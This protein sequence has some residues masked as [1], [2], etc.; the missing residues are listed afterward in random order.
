M[1]K[2]KI[3]KMVFPQ[4]G[5]QLEQITQAL[6]EL[7][8]HASA[9]SFEFFAQQTIDNHG[10]IFDFLTDLFKHEYA[11]KEDARITRW[12]SQSKMKKLH[13]LQDFD[14]SRQPSI[15]PTLISEL[16]S[17]RFIDQGKNVIFL[18]PP[19]VG[20]THLA[21]ALGY[22]AIMKGYEMRF[23]RLNEFIDARRRAAASSVP[24]LHRSLL[25]PKL[26]ILDDVDYY[27]KDIEAG[28]FLFTVLKDRCENNLSTIIT[29]NQNPKD[30]DIF[31]KPTNTPAIL[32]RLFADKQSVT[33]NINGASTR[34][35][36][37]IPEIN[38]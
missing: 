1:G 25:S 36:G 38:A 4:G 28:I 31:G 10:T 13:M 22:E 9:S 20:K 18:G 5:T 35:A 19:G 34:R 24:R 14:F 21:S 33:I 32:D 11:S 16:A 6:N 30:W 29:S 2:K 37:E 12:T 23:V 27:S 15:E 26:L 17:C 7:G 8:L 3:G